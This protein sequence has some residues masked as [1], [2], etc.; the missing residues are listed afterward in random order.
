MKINSV[1]VIAFSL[2]FLLIAKGTSYSAP[3]DVSKGDGLLRACSALEANPPDGKADVMSGA[4]CAGFIEGAFQIAT[5]FVK[6]PRYCFPKEGTNDE[7]I[8]VLL[9]YLHDRPEELHVPS[10]VIFIRAMSKA[11]PCP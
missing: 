2:L 4:S 3:L 9:K 10:G 5:V 1:P 11:F 8:K 7:V 6:P